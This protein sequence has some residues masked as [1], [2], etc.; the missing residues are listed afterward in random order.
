M[1]QCLFLGI[2]VFV[3]QFYIPLGQAPAWLFWYVTVLLTGCLALLAFAS[4]R[5]LSVAPRIS[6]RAEWPDLLVA[7]MLT[8]LAGAL[9]F[10]GLSDYGLW[11]DEDHQIVWLLRAEPLHGA[12]ETY[13]APLDYVFSYITLQMFDANLFAARVWSA[14][15]GTLTVPLLYF[16]VR[17]S[18]KLWIA[19]LVALMAVFH[20][21]LLAYS[22]ECR[23]YIGSV[24]ALG[25]AVQWMWWAW[26]GKRQGHALFGL[27]SSMIVLFFY[28]A[29]LP[30]ILLGLLGVVL[31]FFKGENRAFVRGYWLSFIVAT[32]SWVPYYLA[33]LNVHSVGNPRVPIWDL[34]VGLKRYL[35]CMGSV[36]DVSAF[37]FVLVGLVLLA[38]ISTSR[39]FVRPLF[40][41]VLVYPF[42]MLMFSSPG[43][44]AYFAERF[45][46]LYSFL[47]LI[48]IGYA[49]EAMDGQVKH[50]GF[51]VFFVGAMALAVL[52]FSLRESRKIEETYWHEAQKIFLNDSEPGGLAMVFSLRPV[53]DYTVS[54]F[55]GRE[56]LNPHNAKVKIPSNWESSMSSAH[57][58][59][60]ELSKNP[61]PKYLY[62]LSN[63]KETTSTWNLMPSGAMPG[64]RT[65]ILDEESLMFR[66]SINR[67]AILEIQEFFQMLRAHQ[68]NRE[69]DISYQQLL[70][71]LALLREDC[72]EARRYETVLAQEYDWPH[73]Q[74]Y[75]AALREM[76]ASSCL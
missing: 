8:I 23:P 10:Y 32:L 65:Y 35:F 28:S 41:L 56:L 4:V 29:I 58:L 1:L 53:T 38:R 15:L 19:A 9:R 36:L 20:P 40:W 63:N 55:I 74:Q 52:L 42:G 68:I 64:V 43:V 67:N 50:K 26:E 18:A 75:Q 7:L 45:V 76:F 69:F 13:Q 14:T 30:I 22:R 37:G 51:R 49:A 70:M 66:L 61:N 48:A 2:A 16:L 46:L 27:A 44:H 57:V 59:I 54:G 17:N 33:M 72:T 39:P 12:L 31:L 73:D 62:I 60:L 24:F 11:L 3:L 34:T 6:L 47:V 25:L 5:Q 71:G 21:W